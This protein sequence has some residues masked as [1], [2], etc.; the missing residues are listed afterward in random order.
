[1]EKVFRSLVPALVLA[2]GSSVPLQA[3]VPIG[4]TQVDLGV[5]RPAVVGV[6]IV[7]VGDGYQVYFKNFGTVPVHFGFYLE[8]AQTQDDISTNG[9]I[10]LRPGN[11]TGALSV[12]V[13]RPVQG[14]IR[15]RAAQAAAGGPD[16]AS[17][18]TAE[19]SNQ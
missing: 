13:R 3:Q 6:K 5:N 12:P 7:T 1:M 15:V 18:E 17:P 11:L 8:E 10:H 16:V 9:R 4:W 2:V 19:E 14:I